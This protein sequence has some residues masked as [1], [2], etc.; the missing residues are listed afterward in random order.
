VLSPTG[1]KFEFV[2]DPLLREMRNVVCILAAVVLYGNTLWPLALDRQTE[3]AVWYILFWV[4]SR[5]LNIK[6]RRFGTLCR[7]NLHRWVGLNDNL[8][9]KWPVFIRGRVWSESGLGQ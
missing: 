6:S 9:G 4:F 2:F 3:I 7:F 5:R 1:R 8:A